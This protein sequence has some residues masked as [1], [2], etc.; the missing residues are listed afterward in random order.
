KGT[1]VVVVGVSASGYAYTA[2]FL[3]SVLA[4][5]GGQPA[6]SEECTPTHITHHICHTTPNQPT[7]HPWQ[8]GDCAVRSSG[9]LSAVQWALFRRNEDRHIMI[10]NGFSRNGGAELKSGQVVFAR[11]CRCD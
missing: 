9:P 10:R 1:L 4:G 8:V 5:V 6:W 11:S 2:V 3:C 7:N